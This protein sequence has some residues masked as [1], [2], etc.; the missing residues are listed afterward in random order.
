MTS[1]VLPDNAL[2]KSVL[3]IGAGGGVEAAGASFDYQQPF[4]DKCLQI[5]AACVI[6]LLLGA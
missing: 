6:A 3:K 2:A 1:F 5:V 4:I